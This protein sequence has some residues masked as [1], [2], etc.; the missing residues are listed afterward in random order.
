[1]NFSHLDL[2]ES[3]LERFGLQL[4]IP[5]KAVLSRYCDEL[6]RWNRKIN[7]TGLRGV[8]MVRRLVVVPAWMARQVK[9][10]GVL[11][12]IGSGNGSPAI[13]MHLVSPGL[14]QTHLV[15]ARSKRSAFL[16][17]AVTMLKVSNMTVHRGR[18]EEVARTLGKADWV[19]LQAVPLT[20]QLIDIIKYVCTETTTVVWMTSSSS[21]PVIPPV[22]ILE[23]PHADSKG[24][25]FH[26]DLS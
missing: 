13:P 18:F 5:E 8:D 9:L 26:L 22:R 25:L 10:S 11:V 1:M 2:I 6:A 23:V 15:E 21:Q 19:T 17:H 20:A 14:R 24:F 7:L 12:D 3:E 4:G 16:R